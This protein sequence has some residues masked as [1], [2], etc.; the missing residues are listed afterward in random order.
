VVTPARLKRAPEG[1]VAKS[2]G[3][4]VQAKSIKIATVNNNGT[5]LFVIQE[6]EMLCHSE[7]FC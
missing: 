4:T 2:L 7:P 3:K 1:E 6:G 5:K